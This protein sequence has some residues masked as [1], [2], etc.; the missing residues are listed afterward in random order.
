MA[1]K[2]F[3]KK[4]DY[5]PKKEVIERLMRFK[6]GLE[7]LT[8]YQNTYNACTSAGQLPK[9]I[10]AVCLAEL[11]TNKRGNIKYY[12]DI[13]TFVMMCENGG[14]NRSLPVKKFLDMFRPFIDH[15]LL[16]KLEHDLTNYRLEFFTAADDWI[17]V[18]ADDN[19]HSCMSESD[20]VRCY[21]HPENDL[22][23]ATLYAPGSDTVVARTIVNTKEKWYVRLYGDRLLVD[24]LL[25]LGY[26]RLDTHV[27]PFKMY[28]RTKVL[29]VN[30]DYIT[31]PYFDFSY[32]DLTLHPETYNPD[33]QYLEITIR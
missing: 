23:L 29:P 20:I 9:E 32:R 11:D 19:V 21:A 22:A 24:K 3:K 12:P 17:K 14:P 31:I 8:T 5:L 33:N 30:R 28:A 13:R 18:Y 7:Y 1:L 26:Y 15:A 27:K 4:H 2:A 25:A 6:Y 16:D 10:V